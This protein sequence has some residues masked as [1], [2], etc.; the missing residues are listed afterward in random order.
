[1]DITNKLTIFF[2]TAILICSP[3]LY[4][5]GTFEEFSTKSVIFLGVGCI[6]GAFLEG[7]GG[8]DDRRERDDG[9]TGGTTEGRERE[10]KL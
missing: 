3:I 5:H 1:M 7:T 9:R 6:I 4:H 10:L 8:T 2:T